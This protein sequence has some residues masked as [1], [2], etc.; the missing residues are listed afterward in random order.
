LASSK[1]TNGNTRVAVGRLEERFDNYILGPTGL[2]TRFES[3]EKV[4]Q[5][6]NELVADKIAPILVDHPRIMKD[7]YGDVTA[8]DPEEKKGSLVRFDDH[9]AAHKKINA[10]IIVMLGTTATAIASM[11]REIL[12]GLG[13]IKG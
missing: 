2:L 1:R 12:K 4:V 7:L 8:N 9:V 3:L 10:A 11:W 5:S 13:I 6:T